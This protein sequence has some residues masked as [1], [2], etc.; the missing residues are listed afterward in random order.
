MAG[1]TVIFKPASLTPR[2]GIKI[3]EL[4]HDAGLPHGVLN[5]VTGS[6]KDVGNTI[7]E[8]PRI[9]AISFTG[10][11][12]VGKEL[13][14]GAADQVKR[15]SLEL[16][17]HAPFIVFPDA[18][19]EIVAKAAVIGKFRNNGQVC[20]SPSRFYIHKDV[21]KKFTE[22]EK[23]YRRAIECN[24]NYPLAHF[25]LAIL[26]DEKGDRAAALCHY[27]TALRLD[28]AFSDAHYNLA[29]LYQSSGHV[30]RAVRHWK[31][32]LRADPS[33]SWAA[34]ARQELE[35]LRQEAIVEGA[36]RGGRRGG[37]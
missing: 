25:N 7:V 34:I 14:R 8:E 33:S 1:N 35:K 31:A 26:S 11:T 19:P 21:S 32:Y 4:F 22:A 20:I 3:V 18:D 16:G 36:R 15:L 13:M 29:L 10:S 37:A 23:Y 17:G 27:L 6:G 5:L 30:M 28:P 9:K 12:E 2:T 24:P